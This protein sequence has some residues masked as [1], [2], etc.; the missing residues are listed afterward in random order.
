M[1]ENVNMSLAE[2][3]DIEETCRLSNEDYSSNNA[4]ISILDSCIGN[5]RCIVSDT[6]VDFSQISDITWLV[7]ISFYCVR[8]YM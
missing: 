8:K 1:I 6:D 4:K 3:V 2:N 7:R 5:S